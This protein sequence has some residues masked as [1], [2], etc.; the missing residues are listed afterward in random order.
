MNVMVELEA[1]RLE[2]ITRKSQSTGPAVYKSTMQDMLDKRSSGHFRTI[3]AH[4]HQISSRAETFV[5][6]LSLKVD[7]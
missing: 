7:V 3:R 1:L 5:G 4:R 6:K 2:R